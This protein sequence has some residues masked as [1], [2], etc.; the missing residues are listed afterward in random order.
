MTERVALKQLTASD[1]TFFDAQFR[2]LSV[3]NQKSINL[4]ADPFSS[5]FYPSIAAGGLGVEVEVPLSVTILGPRIADHRYRVTRSVTKKA[6]YKNWRL[7]GAAVPDPAGETGRFDVLV[8]GD[9]AALEFVGDPLPSA[10]TMILVSKSLEPELHSGLAAAI[11]GGRQSMV[12]VSRASLALIADTARAPAD[13]PMRLLLQDQEL[14]ATL[15]DAAFGSAL[16]VAKLRKRSGPKLTA[17]ALATARANA[18]A[19]GADG[20]ALVWV[21]LTAET[22]AGK[23]AN[24]VWTS[25]VDA[26]ASWDFDV[27]LQSGAKIR[28]DAKSTTG[29]FGRIMHMSAAELAAAAHDNVRYDIWRVFK[30]DENGGQLR[31]AED[32]GGFAKTILEGLSLPAGVRPDGFSIDPHCLKSWSSPKII[33]RPDEA[34]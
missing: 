7:N 14:E 21:H 22:A 16:A 1:L 13:H 33:E 31:V 18:E 2:R 34:E 26:A 3:G 28:I 6:A 25:N 11:P 17:A 8:P 4:N 19:V 12:P 32:I 27:T 24:A 29:P 9:I 23:I 10:I 15:E 5:E 20:E 30:I